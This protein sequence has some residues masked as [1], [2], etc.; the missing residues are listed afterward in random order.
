MDTGAELSVAPWSFA[1]DN[2]LSPLEEAIELH[3]ATGEAI[4]T[5]G[6]RIVQL[7]CRGFSFIMDFVIADVSQPL[8]G[9]GSL[10]RENLSLQL[11][12]HTGYQ[13][14]NKAGEHIQLEHSGQQVYLVCFILG[15][16]SWNP[17]W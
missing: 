11:D 17:A 3:T 9:L 8:L 6:I 14:S 2:L 1:E 13:L 4:T 15:S 16:L 5:F 7:E 10:L 12:S